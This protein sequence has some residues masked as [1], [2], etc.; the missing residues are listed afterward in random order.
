MMITKSQ[1]KKVI[2]KY[3]EEVSPEGEGEKEG[4]VAEKAIR[5]ILFI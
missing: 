2:Y 5:I 4:K 3:M 1:C